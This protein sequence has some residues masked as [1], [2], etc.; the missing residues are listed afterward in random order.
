MED[1]NHSTVL[2]DDC[3]YD[4]PFHNG[5]LKIYTI[6]GAVTL[7]NGRQPACVVVCGQGHLLSPVACTSCH[8]TPA[9][10]RIYTL[11]MTQSPSYGMIGVNYVP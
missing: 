10:H 4:I 7:F 8:S 6:K 1:F 11:P 9:V 2:T 5:I 3:I